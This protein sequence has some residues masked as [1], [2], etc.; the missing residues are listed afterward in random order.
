MKQLE[1][2]AALGDLDLAESIQAQ[3]KAFEESGTI[4]TGKS[5]ESI[6]ME[7]KQN[8]EN[9]NTQLKEVYSNAISDLTK[10]KRLAEARIV[11]D[12]MQLVFREAKLLRPSRTNGYFR[13]GDGAGVAVTLTKPFSLGKTEVT[14]GQWKEVM[15]TEPWNGQGDVQADKDCPAT[16]VNWGDATEF[17][18]KLTEIERK[19]GKLKAD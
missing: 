19:A 4:P 15:G 9:A 17:C 3:Q 11:R 12:E 16:Y 1:A 13:M 5:F 14:Q 8:R 2:A 10:Q 6:V 18:K 7:I